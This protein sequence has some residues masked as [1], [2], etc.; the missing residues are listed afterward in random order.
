MIALLLPLISFIKH[1][2]NISLSRVAMN[3]P[4]RYGVR[5]QVQEQE[6]LTL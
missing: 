4:T 1:G 3:K 5:G 2:M 6:G